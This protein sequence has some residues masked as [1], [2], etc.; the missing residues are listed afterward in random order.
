MT[1]GITSDGEG[2]GL[3]EQLYWLN[4]DRA[5]SFDVGMPQAF[6]ATW[7]P[8]GAHIAFLGAPEQG[9]SGVARADA[10]FDLY[11]MNPDG[12]QP[13]ALLQNMH[14]VASMA[15]SADSRW[16]VFPASLTSRSDDAGLWIV[17]ATTGN[18]QQ[19]V[20]GDFAAPVF[21]PDGRQLAALHY[22]GEYPNTKEEIVIVDIG[23][24]P[25]K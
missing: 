23:S 10:A 16:I 15:W 14:Y 22:L 6:A 12:T 18:H 21:S 19:I 3:Y 13:R 11:V 5:E 2:R 20:K 25:A 7:S 17:D 4:P 24:L 9:L 8:D 1:R